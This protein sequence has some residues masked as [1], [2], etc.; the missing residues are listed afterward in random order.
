MLELIAIAGLGLVAGLL[1]GCVGIGGV[2]LVPALTY[3]AGIPIHSAIPAAI[4]AF[5]VSGVVG[6][7]AYW[8]A[9][10]VSWSLAKPL[11]FAAMPSALAGA[12]ASSMAPAGLL[13]A[14]IGLLTAASGL[15]TYFSKVAAQDNSA[16][17]LSSRQ[18]VVAGAVTGFGSA[19]TGTGG[20][21]MLVPILMWL[22]CPVLA[23][24][25]LAQLI[26]LPIALCATAGNLVVDHIDWRLASTLAVGLAIGTYSGARIAHAVPRATLRSLVS[27]V[28]L[29]VGA[30]I[31]VKVGWRNLN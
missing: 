25:G 26:Q 14:S 12:L 5:L 30:V 7:L 1:I 8:R 3:L 21:L 24:V 13:E 10:S 28:L 11:F 19:L 2:I 31:V 6:S 17:S 18:L 22:R 29:I 16:S 4:A 27:L 15:N 20:P 23:A 9:G